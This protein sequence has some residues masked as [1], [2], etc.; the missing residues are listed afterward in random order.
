MNY[1][2]SVLEYSL[3]CALSGFKHLMC[4]PHVPGIFSEFLSY[5]GAEKLAQVRAILYGGYA[6]DFYGAIERAKVD[7]SAETRASINFRRPSIEF[8]QE[9]DRAEF[10]KLISPDLDKV[11]AKIWDC[12]VQATL[13]PNEVDV[14]LRTGGSSNIPALS[15]DWRRS[16][17]G[18]SSRSRRPSPPSL[19]D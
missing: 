14:V 6:Y 12:L 3:Y 10:T 19:R 9:V 7:L 4:D 17:V 2:A 16:S 5:P 11:E 8:D 15:S 13:E 18:T 1:E